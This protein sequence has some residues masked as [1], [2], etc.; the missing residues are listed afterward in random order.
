M[1]GAAWPFPGDDESAQ[2]YGGSQQE[3][4]WVDDGRDYYEAGAFVGPRAA[5]V[6][7]LGH[8]GLGY[9]RDVPPPSVS[10]GNPCSSTPPSRPRITLTLDTLLP[11]P[12]T[13]DMQ[14]RP[15]AG[16]E[17]VRLRLAPFVDSDGEAWAQRRDVLRAVERWSARPRGVPHRQP[18]APRA[19]SR[20]PRH[21]P[22]DASR[23]ILIEA[24]GRRADNGHM[25]QGLGAIDSLNANAWETAARYMA[26]TTADA[27][28]LQE[29]KSAKGPQQV[30][31]ERKAKAMRWS[32]S[33]EPSVVTD[34]DGRS[35]G[36]A[37]AVRSHHGLA[38]P[39]THVHTRS[40]KA[41]F[42]CRWWGA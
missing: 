35:A 21:R 11:P 5:M 37:T 6:F 4:A 19:R 30:A 23:P 27:C 40:L 42:Q 8:W 28:L 14:G 22:Y 20:P 10:G 12:G 15:L 1:E 7:K 36:V 33:V 32:L 39:Q 34:A 9:Y 13:V 2:A 3:H 31:A 16:R 26:A 25:V 38:M 29:L 24:L 17:P 41:R 18:R